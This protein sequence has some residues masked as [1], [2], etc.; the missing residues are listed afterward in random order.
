M[1]S[2]VDVQELGVQRRLLRHRGGVAVLQLQTYRQTGLGSGQVRS[3]RVESGQGRSDCVSLGQSWSGQVESGQVKCDQDAHWKGSDWTRSCQVGTGQTRAEVSATPQVTMGT[4][5]ILSVL[6]SENLGDKRHPKQNN[7][8]LFFV[9]SSV[10]FPLFHFIKA[11]FAF[12]KPN[13][14]LKICVRFFS[15]SMLKKV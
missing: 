11:L 3:G 12:N 5:C 15:S 13:D 2:L 10:H 9:L 6:E 4:K 14:E 1:G 8:P 7:F